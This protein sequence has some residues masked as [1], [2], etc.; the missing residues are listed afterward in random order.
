MSRSFVASKP[1][2]E[3]SL[4]SPELRTAAAARCF[5]LEMFRGVPS[6][7]ACVSWSPP[8]SSAD[9]APACSLDCVCTTHPCLFRAPLKDQTKHLT[10]LV[11]YWPHKWMDSF[12]NHAILDT[13]F[14][15]S[16][17]IAGYTCTS[18]KHQYPTQA[19][20]KSS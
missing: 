13:S 4:K 12:G 1:D 7:L 6:H 5:P 8:D 17:T 16:S 11:C 9:E 19:Q 3:G 15:L 2:G 14:I 10:P 20:P 18:G